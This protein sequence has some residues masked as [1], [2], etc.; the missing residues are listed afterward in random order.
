[1]SSVVVVVAVAGGSRAE[2]RNAAPRSSGLTMSVSG[3]TSFTAPAPPSFTLTVAISNPDAVAATGLTLSAAFDTSQE[4]LYEIGGPVN[5]SPSCSPGRFPL[6]DIP[7]GATATLTFRFSGAAPVLHHVFTVSSASNPNIASASWDVTFLP[8]PTTAD[9]QVAVTPAHGT[10]GLSAQHELSAKNLG[11]ADATDVTFYDVLAEREQ[12]VSASPS[13]GTC[14]PESLLRQVRIDCSVG[15]LPANAT[16]SLTVR[17]K[18][19]PNPSGDGHLGQVHTATPGPDL[20]HMSASAPSVF[21]GR[22]WV[23]AVCASF[24]F[25]D[26]Y[27]LVNSFTVLP[28]DTVQ[29]SDG[30]YIRPNDG[31]LVRADC[32]LVLPDGTIQPASGPCGA[33]APRVPS[34]PASVVAVAGHGSATVSWS[35]SAASDPSSPITGYTVTASPPPVSVAVGPNDTSAVVSGLINTVSYT[36][37]VVAQSGAGS[38]SPATSNPVTPTAAVPDAP[39]SVHAAAGDAA[40]TVTWSTP[41]TDGGS[42]ITSYTVTS[43][44]GGLTETAG[45]TAR[46]VVVS[47]LAN[48]TSY[49]F[50]V[51]ARNGVGASA[52][53][54]PSNAATPVGVPNTVSSS[55]VPSNAG[56]PPNAVPTIFPSRPKIVGFSPSKGKPGALVTIRG[57]RLS[58][59]IAVLFNRKSATFHVKSAT[60]ITVKVPRGATSGPIT[61][62]T[63]TG[64][65]TS[66]R[67]FKVLTK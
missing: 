35:R 10:G 34:P 57:S 50:T 63:S 44:P 1:M 17:T 3:P 7:A 45:A 54:L 62:R 15:T 52:A 56:V 37:T 21:P 31:V 46:S 53:S 6:N 33:K 11:P 39:I 42:P 32:K 18:L 60:L 64:T 40:A 28:D 49:T 38:S 2:A 43:A 25:A 20:T 27:G 55:G 8:S 67:A 24:G 23:C 30:S 13:Q 12:F 16:F 36:F 41:P 65:A 5:C 47:G 14:S 48:G 26:G 22:F 9:W 4:V 29:F 66:S 58:R 59:V 61:V 19:P 51:I